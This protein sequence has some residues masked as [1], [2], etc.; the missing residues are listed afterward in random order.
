[1]Q[2]YCETAMREIA[3][4]ANRYKSVSDFRQNKIAFAIYKI[5]KK[6]TKKMIHYG[7]ILFFILMV[8][9]VVRFLSCCTIGFHLK[10]NSSRVSEGSRIAWLM[11]VQDAIG[12][13]GP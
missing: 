7:R 4:T 2:Q 10:K 3:R 11:Q 12:K 1:M 6:K 9:L 8:V 13:S 5:A